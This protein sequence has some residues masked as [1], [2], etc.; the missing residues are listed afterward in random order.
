VV[1]SLIIMKRSGG[2]EYATSA[3]RKQPR[4]DPVSCQS[5]RK[6]K[7]KCDRL[8]P[9]SGCSSRHLECV[10]HNARQDAVHTPATLVVSPYEPAIAHVTPS[11]TQPQASVEQTKASTQ[12]H[13]RDDSLKTMD[14]LETI[15]MGHWVP[16]AV[17]A[18]LRADIDRGEQPPGSAPKTSSEHLNMVAQN[19][20][21]LRQSPTD[22]DLVSYLPP[23]AEAFSLFRYYCDNLD[24][25]FHAIIPHHVE[26]QIRTIYDQKSRQGTIDLNHAALLFS[27]MAS[28]LHY[29]LPAEPSVP[30]SAYSRTAVFLAGA[31]LIQSNYMAYPTIEGL[32]ATMIIAQNLSSTNLPL[33]V[34]SLFVPR[35]SVGQAISMNLHL[36]DISRPT[37]ER[38]SDD[39][40]AACLELKRRIWWSLVSNDW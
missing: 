32:Q 6:R 38:S 13:P 18:A 24:F 3:T 33:A 40:N 21:T 39:A 17:P 36:V 30:A 29:R 22:I 28:A 14:W 27:I 34:S 23:Q 12:D 9:C 25:H 16:S 35:L 8:L 19:R 31:A 15:V 7:L 10:Y 20:T 4:Q 37:R 5:C 11:E 2:S 1:T 26:Q